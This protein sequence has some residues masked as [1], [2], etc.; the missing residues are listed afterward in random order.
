MII[1]EY[2][3]KYYGIIKLSEI[4]FSIN[5]GNIKI[6]R[7]NSEKFVVF[8]LYNGINKKSPKLLRQKIQELGGKINELK[9]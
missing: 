2:D 8:N 6:M 1:L 3:K 7:V 9:F 4:D 5:K